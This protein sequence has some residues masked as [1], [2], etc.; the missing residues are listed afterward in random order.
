MFIL[1]NTNFF[2]ISYLF[3]SGDTNIEKFEVESTGTCEAMMK[4]REEM[5]E[6]DALRHK[7]RSGRIPFF[8]Y[9]KNKNEY[10]Y[11]TSFS[12]FNKCEYSFLI[13]M[14]GYVT[15]QISLIQP[16]LI[17]VILQSF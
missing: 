10:A 14:H 6:I 12:S 15:P 3:S 17:M 11:V 9:Q 5:A 13:E 8:N 1:V 2:T 7:Y 4:R 16:P